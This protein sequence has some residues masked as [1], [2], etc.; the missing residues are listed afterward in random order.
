MGRPKK[1]NPKNKQIRIRVT[2]YEHML[3]KE[4][5]RMHGMSV[6]ELLRVWIGLSNQQTKIMKGAKENE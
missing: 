1:D 3:I 5:A 4:M 6:T 2:E